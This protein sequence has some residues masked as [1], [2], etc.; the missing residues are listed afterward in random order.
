MA[1]LGELV[2]A[3]GA[4]AEP[5]RGLRLDGMLAPAGA[6][7]GARRADRGGGPLRRRIAGAAAGGRRRADRGGA[8]DRRVPPG[9]HAWPTAWAAASTRSPS[10]RSRDRSAAFLQAAGGTRA[11]LAGRL[12][13][14]DWGGRVRVKLH[15]E[16]AAPA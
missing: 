8:A 2:A 11:H 7:P 16:D 5:A 3:Q 4:A 10:A 13:R 9:A 1:R 6:A 15:V 14:D 12:E